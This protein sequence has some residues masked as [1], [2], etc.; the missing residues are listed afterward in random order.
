ML[1]ELKGSFLGGV[2]VGEMLHPSYVSAKKR[3][4]KNNNVRVL[5]LERRP[6][7]RRFSTFVG[8]FLNITQR[9][10]RDECVQAPLLRK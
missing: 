6:I 8:A 1:K 9:K 7:I 5:F 2:G 4:T 10:A 3:K